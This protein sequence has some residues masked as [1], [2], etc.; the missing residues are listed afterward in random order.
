[1]FPGVSFLSE[2]S[3]FLLRMA[4]ILSSMIYQA[5]RGK[6]IL[7]WVSFPGYVT[8]PSLGNFTQTGVVY[9]AWV[10]LASLGMV[11]QPEYGYPT[12]VKL[13]KLSKITQ[14]G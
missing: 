2:H 7:G 14:P 6:I 3:H 9:P 8:L 10:W 5:V 1:M 13:P 12:L 11:T 4:Q